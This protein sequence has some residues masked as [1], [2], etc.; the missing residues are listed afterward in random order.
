M[1]IL[2]Q[3][4]TER[5]ILRCFQPQDAIPM[6][7]LLSDPD[8]SGT[9]IDHIPTFTL[10]DAEQLA[11]RSAEALRTGDGY[12]FAVIRKSN[13]TLV[14]SINLRLTPEQPRAELAYWFGRPYWWQGYATEAA[15]HMV[16]FAFETLNLNRIYAYCLTRNKAAA[17]VLEKVGLQY[18]GTMRQRVVKNNM[19]EDVAFYGM[20][21]ADYQSA[22]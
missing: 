8:V 6:H 17:R 11:E 12:L 20:I 10:K 22:S 16:Q 5:L 3:L 1:S 9:L 4:E 18:E 2:T 21:R 14:G 7:E 19:P 13:D 15:R